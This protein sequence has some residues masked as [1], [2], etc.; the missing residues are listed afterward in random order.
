VKTPRIKID[1][2]GEISK[3]HLSLLKKEYGKYVHVHGN[4]EY[5]NILDTPWFKK[6]K[7]HMTPGVNLRIYRKNRGLTQVQLGELLGDIP[8]QHISNMEN[9]TRQISLKT[10]KRLAK[11]FNV[12]VEKFV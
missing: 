1:I 2:E 3:N 5:I 11:I 9:G 10:A 8:K 12:S 6:M 4:D 7:S